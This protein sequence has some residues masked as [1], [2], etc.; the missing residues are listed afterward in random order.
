MAASG[1]RLDARFFF[2]LRKLPENRGLRNVQQLGGPRMFSSRAT[3]RKYLSARSSIV[4]PPPMPNGFFMD[5]Q[6][7]REESQVVY[8][9]GMQN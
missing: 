7:R 1:E 6:Q 8:I 5:I 3:I 2:E 9:T 4:K